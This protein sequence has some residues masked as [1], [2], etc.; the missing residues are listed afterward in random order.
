MKTKSKPKLLLMAAVV[1][2]ITV[3][4]WSCNK[5][6][7]P[8][9]KDLRD[10]KLA[11]LEDSLRISDSLR[12]IGNAGVV[13][14]SITIVDGSTSSF[15]ANDQTRGSRTQES[16][17]ALTDAIVTISQYGKTLTDTTDDSGMVV[18]NGF[19]RS[20]VNIT[21]KKPNFTTVSYIAA[22]NVQDST[23]T[24]TISFVGNIIPLFPTT[25]ST[26]ATISGRATIQTNLTNRTRENVP[27]GTT[28]SAYIDAT[29]GSDFSYTFLTSDIEDVFFTSDCGCQFAYVGNILQATYQTGI[30]GTVTNGSYSLTVPAAIDGLPLY[31]EYSEVAADQTLFETSGVLPGDRTAT[32]RTFYE[33][34]GS[35]SSIPGGS[36]ATVAFQTFTTAATVSG[37]VI[38]PTS[39]A[40][41]RINVT[42]TGSGYAG[43][44]IV[45]ITGGGGTGAAATA[46]MS[47]GRITGINLTNAGSGYTSAP[48]VKFVTGTGADADALQ[49]AQDGTIL[50]VQITNS[51]SGYT[52]APTVTFGAPT[53]TGLVAQVTAQGTAVIT[54]GRVTSVTI[55]NPGAAYIANAT[56]TFSAPTTGTTATGVALFS[57]QSI[58]DIGVTAPGTDYSFA[59][60]VVIDAP[61]IAGGVQATAT[62]TFN[63]VTRQVTG[64]TI[65]NAGS[66]YA[67]LP[68]VSLV[69]NT[70]NAA[71]EV[72]LAGGSVLS[73]DM[74]NQGEGYT[75][76]P[77]VTFTGGGGNGA[78]GTA[79][80]VDGRV[81]GVNITNG[82]TG[83]T[84]SPTLT[85]DSGNGASGVATVT[86]GAITG[87]TVTDGG[88]FFTAPPRVVIT[89]S[90]GGG[91]T[92]TAAIANGAVTTVTM[93]SGGSGYLDGNTPAS[94]EGFNATHGNYIYTKPGLSYI[95]DIYY[96]TGLRS[97][98]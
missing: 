21:I 50:S 25:G 1:A 75:Q 53:G 38:S 5:D 15:Y 34:F 4:T 94:P 28:V 49:L 67:G 13:N 46:T 89:S 63:P 2:V 39:G 87:I 27:D 42:N 90:V 60:A 11:Y 56:V 62:A 81:V 82:G 73:V 79:I 10:D 88:R 26:T 6:D 70:V 54:N 85:F 97:P 44:P 19:F 14:Y 48:T 95:N 92:A 74:N 47:N 91:A 86:N 17:S 30:Y 41:D 35:V 29:N 71:T 68:N 45:D 72:F 23:R 16:K 83:Y 98:N 3:A 32:Y 7:D 8:S 77:L 31:L 51:G 93:T 57:G 61:T 36:S 69:S 24:G 66:G 80:V 76:P 64:I 9:L 55:T 12:L 37:V 58:R 59:P 33:P 65:T 22:V 18:F 84:S 96:G 43:T 52:T 78:A 20:A 40:I